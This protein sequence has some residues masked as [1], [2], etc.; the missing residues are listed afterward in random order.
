MFY[1]LPMRFK[2]VILSAFVFLVSS[3]VYAVPIKIEEISNSTFEPLSI[4]KSKER[5]INKK[6]AFDFQSE[7]M[8]GTN[9]IRID[10]KHNVLSITNHCAGFQSDDVK[11]FTI[12]RLEQF[13]T[14]TIH[15]VTENGT[16]NIFFS[17]TKNKD[18]LY[19]F[20][21]VGSEADDT[22]NFKDIYYI[23]AAKSKLFK[24]ISC[25]DFDG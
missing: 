16:G 17:V 6:Y 21:I 23:N 15:I 5:K 4:V 1:Q 11:K 19:V 14:K 8:C 3:C 24:K 25:G 22:Y 13:N 7:C 2:S 10:Q 20:R 9:N 18:G 12:R